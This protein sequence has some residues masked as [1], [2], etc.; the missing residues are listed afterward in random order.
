MRRYIEREREEQ[1]ACY[2]Q[3]HPQGQREEK[4]TLDFKD[5]ATTFISS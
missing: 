3:C 4:S 2:A 5:E 1:R